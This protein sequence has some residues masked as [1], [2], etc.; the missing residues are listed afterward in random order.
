[1]VKLP[2]VYFI[3]IMERIDKQFKDQTKEISYLLCKNHSMKYKN[4]K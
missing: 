1:M 2:N 3:I 4:S